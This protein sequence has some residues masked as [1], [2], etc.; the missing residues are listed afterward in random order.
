MIAQYAAYAMATILIAAM[1][2]E[3][4][5]GRIPN[6]L[7]VLPFVIF[8]AVLAMADDHSPLYWQMIVAAGVFA[9][10]LLLFA[11]GGMGA[12][13]V[14]L[15]AGAVLFVPFENAFYTLLIYLGVFF[16]S[17]VV[18]IQFRKFFGSEDSKWHLMANAVLPL[19]FSIGVACIFGMFVV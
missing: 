17:S 19:S 13:A 11:V 16:V 18:F 14:K 15:I 1:F 3:I 4:R 6:W 10:G 7:T 8:A 5:T 2:F 9:F 12:G